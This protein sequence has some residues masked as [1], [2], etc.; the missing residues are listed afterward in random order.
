MREEDCRIVWKLDFFTEP[1]SPI[2]N[3][4]VSLR[5]DMRDVFFGTAIE[6]GSDWIGRAAHLVPSASPET[7]FE[8]VYSSWYSFHQD[9]TDREIEAECA[10]AAKLGTR[11][12]AA[13]NEWGI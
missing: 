5:F 2:R 4:S 11:I 3:Y 9:V 6:E 12:P 13:R 8:P 7:A 10:E 1:E